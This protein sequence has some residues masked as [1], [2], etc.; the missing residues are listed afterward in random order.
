MIAGRPVR[1]RRHSRL[2][3]TAA[4]VDV[5]TLAA[6]AGCWAFAAAGSSGPLLA[7]RWGGGWCRACRPEPWGSRMRARCGSRVCRSAGLRVRLPEDQ[8]DLRGH[9]PGPADR[10]GASAAGGSAESPL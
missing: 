2:L 9:Q 5:P 8:P 6:D 4:P 10:D 3:A 7:G 1:R